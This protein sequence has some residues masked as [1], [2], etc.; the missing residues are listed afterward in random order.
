[1]P[2]RPLFPD[3]PEGLPHPEPLQEQL[4]FPVS[5][6]AVDR[7][8]AEIRANPRGVIQEEIQHTLVQPG[9]AAVVDGS[10]EAIRREGL[11][12]DYSGYLE[13]HTVTLKILRT[14]AEISGIP[15][16]NVSKEMLGA[17]EEDARMVGVKNAEVISASG[18]NYKRVAAELKMGFQRLAT[19]EPELVRGVLEV[20]RDQSVRAQVEAFQ[21]E[22]AAEI[23][24]EEGID[25]E[26]TALGQRLMERWNSYVRGDAASLAAG[27]FSVY[28][29]IKTAQE[30]EDLGKQFKL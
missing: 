26:E 8:L 21:R 11:A 6:E 3:A 13:A 12:P 23:D 1:M 17:L 27:V 28:V 16:P 7:A 30:N 20:A 29:P 9:L 24:A 14:Q 15:L 2:E 18:Q 25:P 19:S 22:S 5:K 4:L 10:L